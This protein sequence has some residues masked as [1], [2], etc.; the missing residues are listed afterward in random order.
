MGI[1]H[2]KCYYEAVTASGGIRMERG[3]EWSFDIIDSYHGLET[4]D[5]IV[6]AGTEELGFFSETDTYNREDLSCIE[7]T[8]SDELKARIDQLIRKIENM[9]KALAPAK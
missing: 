2:T 4:I 6:K 5:P 3:R 7:Y 9:Q 1:C 8:V